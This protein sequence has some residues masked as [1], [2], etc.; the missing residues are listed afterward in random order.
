MQVVDAEYHHIDQLIHGDVRQV[1]IDEW[2][3]GS[4]LKYSHVLRDRLDLETQYIRAL[5]DDGGIC[6]CLWGVSDMGDHGAVWLIGTKA[7]EKVGRRIHKFWPEEVGRMHMRHST[8]AA[9]AYQNNALHLQWLRQIGFE[10]HSDVA[11]G[12]AAIPFTLFVR[13]TSCVIQ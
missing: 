13:Q 9:L 4:G 5:L 10:H 1:D 3:L 6:I 7:A 12:P 2:V 11:L 8:L